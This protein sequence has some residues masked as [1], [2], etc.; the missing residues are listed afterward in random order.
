MN[1][2]SLTKVNFQHIKV[3]GLTIFSIK[4]SNKVTEKDQIKNVFANIALFSNCD[5]KTIE[6]FIEQSSILSFEKGKV[7]FVHGEP[8]QRFFIIMSGWVK[9][10]RETLEGTQA[11]LDILTHGHIFGEGSI[12]YDDAYEYSAEVIE[13]LKIIS[14]PLSLLKSEISSNPKIAVSMLSM[15]SKRRQQQDKELEHLVIQNAPQRIGCF[16]LR[17]VDQKKDGPVT[18]DLPYDKTLLA[19]RLGMKPETFSRALVKLKEETGMRV[20]GS[21]IELDS[22]QHLAEYVCGACSSNYPCKDINGKVLPCKNS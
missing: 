15:T 8:A 3:F 2:I 5:S 22:K 19:A 14:V 13:D 1:V 10:F 4:E 11:V 21:S 12:F 16:L 6:N 18:I 9:L 17:L 20:K 7:I